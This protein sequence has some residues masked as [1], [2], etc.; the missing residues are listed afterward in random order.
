VEFYYGSLRRGYIGNATASTFSLVAE[1]NC[2][3]NLFTGGS[4]RMI[5]KNNGL[6]GFGRDPSYT[7]DINGNQ[8]VFNG[9]NGNDSMTVYGPNASWN[10]YLVVGSGTD[11]SGGSTAQVISTNGNLHLDGGNSNSIY[12]GYYANSRGTPNTHEFYGQ[13]YRFFDMPQNVASYAQIAVVDGATLRKSQA[14]NKL[15]YFNNNVAWGGGVNMTYAFYLYN[16]TCSV[17]IWGKNSGYYYGAGMMQ[18]MIRV[19][20]QSAGTYYYYPINAFVNNGYN[21]FTVPLDY[22]TTFPYTGWYDIYVYSTSGWVTDGNDQ[23]TIGVSILP[24][25]GF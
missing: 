6:T 2:D 24:V 18:T 25:N 17:Y 10:S 1:N 3:F 5:V 4:N 22:A 20:S 19:Y 7:V 11:R 21:H 9:L 15:V 13:N 16:T 8:R 23:L 12:Y 14:V